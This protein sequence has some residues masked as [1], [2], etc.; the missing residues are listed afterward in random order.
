MLIYELNRI[1]LR[2]DSL[3]QGYLAETCA[4]GLT[5]VQLNSPSADEIVDSLRRGL[6]PAVLYAL[7]KQFVVMHRNNPSILTDRGK[8]LFLDLEHSPERISLYIGPQEECVLLSADEDRQLFAMVVE[9][10]HEFTLNHVNGGVSQ[11]RATNWELLPE[12]AE[13][14]RSGAYVPALYFYTYD[15]PASVAECTLRVEWIPAA[16]AP[17]PPDQVQ[18]PELDSQPSSSTDE[19]PLEEPLFDEPV[20]CSIQFAHSKLRPA[21]DPRFRGEI[22]IGFA[23]ERAE[24]LSA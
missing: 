12:R 4:P 13:G 15:S 5:A 6:R 16:V 8:V 11:T 17:P 7:L 18:A 22:S 3:V 21:A 10:R 24:E 19:L 1:K 20:P 9:E 14:E 23:P 2:L